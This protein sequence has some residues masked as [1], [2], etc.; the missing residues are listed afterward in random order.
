MDG[1]AALNLAAGLS[2]PPFERARRLDVSAEQL[3]QQNIV[4]FRNADTRAR[5]F[6]LLR[7]Q[8]LRRAQ[9]DGLK[10]LGIA[11]AAPHVGKTFV[12][13]NLAAALSRIADLNVILV[14]LDL[15]RPAVATRLSF[16][17]NAP[18]VHDVLS[19]DAT[20][21]QAARRIGD[22]RL[23]VVP[24]FQ[25]EVATGELLTSA[26]GDAL[27]AA[28]R[29]VPAGT[30]V[31]VDMPPIFADDDAVIIGRHLDGFLLVVE[32]GRTTAKQA[33]ETVR[34]LAPTPLIGS[35]LNRYRSQLLVDEYGYGLSY[36]YGGYY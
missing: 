15:H 10:V 29:D 12:A 27:F 7:S 2:F 9:E 35:I 11:S 18:G 21:D 28:M 17:P 25:R 33:K 5:P 31:L 3:D 1:D 13:T 4:G 23:L 26:R 30:I 24:G 22:E 19:G 6:K 36:G 16:D 20:L 32:D 8:I 34:V 14:D